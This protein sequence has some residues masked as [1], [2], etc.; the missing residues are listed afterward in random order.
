MGLLEAQVHNSLREFLRQQAQPLWTHHLT[1]GRLVSRALRLQRSALIQTGIAPS[2][3]YLSY[4]LPALLSE[5][6]LLLV[7]PDRF[8]E[9][10]EKIEIPQLLQW[11]NQHHSSVSG[12]HLIL[13]TPQVWLSDR[14]H[15]TGQ[16]PATIPTIIDQADFL[17]EWTR[18]YLTFNLNT[19]D[20]EQLM[21][22]APQQQELIRETRIYLTKALFLHP[23]NPYECYL[24]EQP[25]QEYLSYLLE[26][27]EKSKHFSP[28]FQNFWHGWQDNQ[29][30]QLRWATIN[31]KTGKFSLHISPINLAH[32]L[33]DCWQMPLVLIGS[34]L[35]V[36]KEAQIFRKMLGLR[37]LLCLKFL[38]SRQNQ[39]IQLYLPD[40]LLPP[41]TP[42]FKN[43]IFDQI[44]QLIQST[45]WLKSVNRTNLNTHLNY[46]YAQRSNLY[47]PH[48]QTTGLETPDHNIVILLDDVPLKA[49]LGTILA[50][51]FG[52]KVQVE[53]TKINHNS[54]L[55]S[56]WEFWHDNQEN[57]PLP[58]LLII[59]TLPL[60]SLEHPLVV[61]R[62]NYH[63]KHHQDWFRE[64][65][66]PTALQA[67]QRAVMPLRESQGVVTILDNRVNS[68]SYGNRILDALE[69]YA[70]SNYIDRNWF[71]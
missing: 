34:F 48:N 14:F 47:D 1:M 28:A 21:L 18:D 45:L 52:A 60:P 11:L 17:E 55:I 35:D 63:K 64:Y 32:Y 15:K 3:Y 20:W 2:R 16:F 6:P 46:D 49:Q 27:L 36:D 9:Q 58:Q 12:Q 5:Q 23:Q 38:P 51:E 67:I 69:P 61:S 66:L 42:E 19:E 33:Q 29:E 26:R 7:V 53:N 24:L 41:N 8:K 40:R 39:S 57:L 22:T 31:R 65:L 56:G 25:E 43:F 13:T 44:H 30:N 50:A 68:Y 71:H 70:K 10:L 54:I 37:D 62:V 59:A 4:L